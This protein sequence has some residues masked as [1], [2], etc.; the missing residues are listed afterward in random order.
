MTE[1]FG[2]LISKMSESDKYDVPEKIGMLHLKKAHISHL[3]HKANKG[4]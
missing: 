2:I 4:Y 3:L 1:V